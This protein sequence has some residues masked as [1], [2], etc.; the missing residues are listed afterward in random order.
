MLKVSPIKCEI[1]CFV[2]LFTLLFL[3]GIF[4]HY[5]GYTFQVVDE[6]YCRNL[7][8]WSLYTTENISCTAHYHSGDDLFENDFISNELLY[9]ADNPH[10]QTY[11]ERIMNGYPIGDS[12]GANKYTIFHKLNNFLPPYSSVNFSALFLIFISFTLGYVIA[13]LMG[14]GYYYAGILGLSLI[15][16]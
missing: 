3:V 7:L 2:I 14:F 6:I 10:Q 16:I 8:P 1:F 11:S 5:T 4:L 13:R 15:H 12:F 9:L